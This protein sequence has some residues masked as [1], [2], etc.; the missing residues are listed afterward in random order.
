MITSFEFWANLPDD[1]KEQL[2]RHYYN[3]YKKSKHVAFNEDDARAIENAKNMLS[4]MEEVFG[5]QVKPEIL[6]KD[7]NDYATMND[8]IK[9]IDKCLLEFE[10]KSI[11]TTALPIKLSQAATAYI[12]IKMLIASSFGGEITEDEWNDDTVPKYNIIR[13]FS[14]NERPFDVIR[15]YLEQNSPIAFKSEALANEFIKINFRLLDDFFEY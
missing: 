5:E 1:C 7:W 4:K 11:R 13:N 15:I 14:C 10:E 3:V 8:E 2:Q 6:W 12:K 9:S